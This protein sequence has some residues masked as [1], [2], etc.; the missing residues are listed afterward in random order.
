M[1]KTAP[2]LKIEN[3]TIS[4]GGIKALNNVSFGV[5]KG[6]IYSIIGPNGAGKTTIFNCISGVYEP[7]SGKIFFKGEE[8]TY[9]KP[10]QIAKKGIARTFQNI[11]LFSH[12]T[13]MDNLMLGRHLH[14]RTGVWRGA[15]FIYKGSNA[16]REE[17]ENR[18]KV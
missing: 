14:M 9:L 4:F 15:T 18:R 6:A 13:T 11:E 16:V 7:D 3:L 8:I 5:E 10:F 1:V 2:I 17:I 12:M